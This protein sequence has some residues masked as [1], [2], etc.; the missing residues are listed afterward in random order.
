MAG[1]GLGREAGTLRSQ[2]NRAASTRLSNLA[3]SG[4]FA[5]MSATTGG[6]DKT[7]KKARRFSGAGIS[8]VGT[9]HTP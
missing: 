7:S 3:S 6:T 2:R 1:K 9:N 8:C 5:S 4:T